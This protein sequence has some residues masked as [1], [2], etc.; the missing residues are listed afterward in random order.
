[1]KNKLFKYIS[2]FAALFLIVSACE[3]TDIQKAN[4]A[5]DFSKIVPIVQGVNGPA[6][7]TQTFSES[8]SV[9]YYRGGSSWSWSATGATI[10]S[11]SADGHD[12]EVLFADAGQA[13]LTVTETTMG[14]ITSEPYEFTVTVAEFCPMTRDDFLGTWVGTETGD[15]EIDPL[16]ITFIAGANANEIVAEATFSTDY[17]YDGNIPAFLS[18]VFTGWGET[19]QAGNGNE[20]DVV[21]V[22]NENGSLSIGFDYWGQTLPGPWDYWYF[23]SG[24]WSGCGDAPSMDFDFNL[25]WDG[26]APGTAQY[27][28]TIHLEKQ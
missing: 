16:T 18:D 24:L 26:S 21:I 6:N 9:N 15:S 5:Y 11:T 19:F 14:G 25:D 12:A 8:Y 2:F 1:M 23:G 13:V 7:A 20:G 27:T 17:D 10:S 28:S 4:E 3:K 22:I